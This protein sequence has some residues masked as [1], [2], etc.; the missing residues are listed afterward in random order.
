MNS[1]VTLFTA[2]GSYDVHKI[3]LL[4]KF[5]YHLARPFSPWLP[6]KS[7]FS[8]VDVGEEGVQILQVILHRL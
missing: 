8:T 2:N 7:E 1:G 6:N 5:T 4:A 3:K